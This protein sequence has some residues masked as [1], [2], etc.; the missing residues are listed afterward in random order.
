M[1]TEKDYCDYETCVSLREIGCRI[2]TEW[3]I[4][5]P[6]YERGNCYLCFGIPRETSVLDEC[7]YIPRL[8]LYEAQKWL[9]EEKHIEVV[10]LSK[11][12]I[13]APYY[14]QVY[15]EDFVVSDD[16]EY[17]TYEEAL[18]E[19]VRASIKILQDEQKENN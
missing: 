10:V 18:S 14:F 17:S 2:E 6:S 4:H 5:Q 19:G 15:T 1:L 7:D 16:K 3:Y 9:R 13:G 8:S 11:G 12:M